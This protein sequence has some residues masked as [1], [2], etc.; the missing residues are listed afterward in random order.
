MAGFTQNA[1]RDLIDSVLS[2]VDS[3]VERHGSYDLALLGMIA[4]FVLSALLYLTI[5]RYRYTSDFKVM[6]APEKAG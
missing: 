5:G 1:A 4:G 2:S 6:A 3:V